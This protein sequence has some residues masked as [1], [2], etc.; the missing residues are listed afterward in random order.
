MSVLRHDHILEVHKA[1]VTSG[2]AGE[3]R[4]L[5][6]ELDPHIR[7]ML[8]MQQGG[9]P[10]AQMLVDLS[11]LNHHGELA[12]GTVP[13]HIWLKNAVALVGPRA[14]GNVFRRA[15]KTSDVPSAALELAS[16]RLPMTASQLLGRDQ[17]LAR[18]DVLWR[19]GVAKVVSI[20]AWGG[21][22]K[23]ALVNTWLQ[24]LID[25]PNR[26]ER[27]FTW[28]F[29]NQGTTEAQESADL[30]FAAA[31]EEFGD[32]EPSASRNKGQRLAKL[33]APQRALLVL[34]GLE[35]LQHPAGSDEG[36]L[37]DRELRDLI[38]SLAQH[39]RGLC[40]ITSRF[41]V[42]EVDRPSPMTPRL[43]LDMLAPSAGAAL[44]RGLGID[45]P[46]AE[47]EDA[48]RDV[49]GHCLTLTLLGTYITCTGVADIR[50]RREVGVFE[51]DTAERVRRVMAHYEEWLKDRPEL[52][53]LEVIG[54]FDR[55]AEES[56]LRTLVER[57]N[58]VGP[59]GDRG[60]VAAFSTLQ[61]ARL[62]STFGSGES[63]TIDAHPLVREHFGERFRLRHPEAFRAAHEWLYD[64]FRG[65]AEVLPSTI[66][67]LG[68]LYAAVTHGCLAGLHA[69]VLVEVYWPR[70][71]RLGSGPPSGS[72]FQYHSTYM[73]GAF[74]LELTA[75]AR[76]FDG[77]W[78]RTVPCLS[79]EARAFLF[80][81]AGYCLRS[82]GRVEEGA[83]AMKRALELD[84]RLSLWDRAAS[85][86]GALSGAYLSRGDLH[87]ALHHARESV[88]CAELA[89]SALWRAYS[90]TVMAYVLC[91]QGSATEAEALFAQAET[92]A[93]ED[94][95]APG[96][97]DAMMCFRH[98][99]LLLG[100]GRWK[101]VFARIE[102]ILPWAAG[103][104]DLLVAG[105]LL[106]CKARA[107]ALRARTDGGEAL[108]VAMQHIDEAMTWLSKAS[109]AHW[110]PFGLLARAALLRELGRSDEALADVDT[111]LQ[112]AQRDGF[113]LW[114]AD[115]RLERARVLFATGDSAGARQSLCAAREIVERTGYW[116]REAELTALELT[117]EH[118]PRLR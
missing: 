70:I 112:I 53:M 90:R 16:N 116:R 86:A 58:P 115:G 35:P 64:H 32:P 6:V 65:R 67:E 8:P 21:V 1:A 72:P 31:L 83:L 94:R 43:D 7:G 14:E 98:C 12:D 40:V 22:G 63:R 56:V 29:Y 89:E 88:R 3:R 92:L 81:H 110:L 62:T 25:G 45:G 104:N 96:I 100:Q 27:L 39:N 71:L 66:A 102:K 68:P 4:A 93:N 61:R 24:R 84:E 105:L 38:R 91:H 87:N 2:L 28:S 111:A 101:E 49:G 47:L 52:V 18:L 74:G 33:I 17:E 34:D 26:P 48:S 13:L 118:E 85:D 51:G 11:E 30:F 9:A 42:T 78:S 77:G 82:V 103:R 44:L 59:V 10:D 36:K 55:P 106:G 37:R 57:V 19:D 41:S 109:M 113:Q 76:F 15:L 117:A 79:E 99:E 69:R 114:I 23:S 60:W 5:L 107:H 80:M 73:L 20:I 108:A 50:R 95:R 46:D 97:L 75:I 54:L